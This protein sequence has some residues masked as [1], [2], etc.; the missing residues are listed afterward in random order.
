MPTKAPRYSSEE[1]LH[2]FEIEVNTFE[3]LY[4]QEVVQDTIHEY[5]RTD[6][7]HIFRYSGKGNVHYVENKKIAL[8]RDSLLIINRNVL[9][10]Y[11]EQRCRGDMVL[12]TDT[13]FGST[14]EKIDFLNS[15]AL[16]QGS[17]MV[18]PLMSESFAAMVDYYFAQMKKQHIEKKSELPLS[19]AI[20]LRNCLH[21]LL[22]T[23]EREYRLR[24]ASLIAHSHN[25]KYMQQ[26]KS[27]LDAHF[28]A[29][30]QVA[31]YA[32]Q[33]QVSEKKLSHI[34]HSVHGFSA[35][36]YINERVLQEAIWLL[37]NTTLNQGEIADKLGLD[38][39]YFVKFFRRHT[40]STP[41]KYRQK[42]LA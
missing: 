26:F 8:T 38:F 13:F 10:K 6:F 11:A 28:Q 33:L 4:A 16:L 20:L 35:K 37:K 3:E 32:E 19:T 34:T 18:I 22:L 1:V 36:T 25:N 31:F 7:Y 15:C 17:Y 12:F 30:K 27:L 9:H 21:N 39:T 40:G 14:H 24:N 42:L 29:Q 23:I 2:S 5:H 41:A